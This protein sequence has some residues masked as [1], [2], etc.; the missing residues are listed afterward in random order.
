MPN[1]ILYLYGIRVKFSSANLTF[2]PA[3]C[4]DARQNIFIKGGNREKK[5]EIDFTWLRIVGD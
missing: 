5:P 3:I 2:Q 4:Y 1:A